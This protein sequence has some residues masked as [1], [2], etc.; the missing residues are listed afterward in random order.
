[1]TQL[2]GGKIFSVTSKFTTHSLQLPG[3]CCV[4]IQSSDEGEKMPKWSRLKHLP[5]MSKDKCAVEVKAGARHW[6]IHGRT[7]EI[8]LVNQ[9][10]KTN[11]NWKHTHAPDT[12]SLDKRMCVGNYECRHIFTAYSTFY[13]SLYCKNNWITPTSGLLLC[14]ELWAKRKL[15]ICETIM[16]NSCKNVLIK[17]SHQ[18][19]LNPCLGAEGFWVEG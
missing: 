12:E 4:Q 3:S 10:R 18:I 2:W 15:N 11:L 17:N 5:K 1:M 13:I 9:T 19:H 7:K 6:N 14:L 8:K 16:A